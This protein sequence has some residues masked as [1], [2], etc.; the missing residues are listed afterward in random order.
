MARTALSRPEPGPL[1]RTETVLIP[2]SIARRAASSAATC[3]AKGVLFREPLNPLLP[4]VAQLITSPFKSVIVM[5]VLLNVALMCATPAGTFLLA[6]FFRTGA[7]A[8][9]A[10]G[11]AVLM[12][13]VFLF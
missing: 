11:F 5:I 8:A 4:A 12:D 2:L 9:V 1:T 13:T 10:D 6:F 3:A 7:P